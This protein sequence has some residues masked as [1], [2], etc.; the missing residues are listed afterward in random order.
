MRD[1]SG[2]ERIGLSVELSLEAEGEASEGQL[3]NR[4]N[5][6]EQAYFG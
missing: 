4:N 6:L 1:K 2:A 5:F 3:E